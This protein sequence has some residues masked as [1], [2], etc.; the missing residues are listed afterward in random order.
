MVPV[1]LLFN[2]RA[3]GSGSPLEIGDFR[4]MNGAIP[5][6]LHGTFSATIEIQATI[7]LNDDVV[8]G[9]CN[10]VTIEGGTFTDEV[11]TALFAPFTHIKGY[12]SSYTSG[13]INL[14]VGI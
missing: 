10:W 4:L 3:T 2:T 1:N 7:A 6:L 13:T 9:N 8:L 11:A 12:V 14:K 5:I